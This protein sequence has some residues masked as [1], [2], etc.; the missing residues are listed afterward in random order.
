MLENKQLNLDVINF[1]Y[2]N[3]FAL[4]FKIDTLKYLKFDY[5]DSDSP[6]L[7]PLNST[8]ANGSKAQV[9]LVNVSIEVNFTYSYMLFNKISVSNKGYMN[10]QNLTLPIEIALSNSSSNWT[11]TPQ[12]KE[13]MQTT[14]YINFGESFPWCPLQTLWN[15]MFLRQ[16]E[17]Q[18]FVNWLI[19][20]LNPMLEGL[21]IN[22]NKQLS[23]SLMGIDFIA[24]LANPISFSE[25]V[26]DQWAVKLNGSL[27]M[28][29]DTSSPPDYFRPNMN[30]QPVG[31]DS[32][33]LFVNGNVVNNLLWALFK[34]GKGKQAI[35]QKTLDTYK[36]DLVTLYTDALV[37]LF[38]N[39]MTVYAP[40]K[41][42]WIEVQLNDYDISS[43]RVQ[44]RQ[45]RLGILLKADLYLYVDTDSSLY[46]Q[47][48]LAQCTTC[49]EAAK[50]E[51]DLFICT[52]ATFT[53]DEF[54][55]FNSPGFDLYQIGKTTSTFEFDK[56][57]FRNQVD[58]MVNSLGGGFNNEIS[59]NGTPLEGMKPGMDILGEMLHLEFT[60]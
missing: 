4:D 31:A 24:S 7:T 6:M 58:G 27:Q 42:M 43:T 40:K 11:L 47:A 50:M 52:A 41:G 15:I 17:Q 49:T 20:K 21:N 2:Q 1:S 36:I 51:V 38:P 54:F 12:Q 9:N 34:S 57:N 60:V 53:T 46:P 59:I 10:L 35:S 23:K 5:S 3:L 16:S 19:Q 26:K 22:Y 33:H 18:G 48:S 30:I 44:M 29:K 37:L 45:G 25:V 56:E 28:S 32:T 14:L 39:I 8:L 55:N 13:A